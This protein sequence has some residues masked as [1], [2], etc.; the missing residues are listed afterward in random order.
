MV[1]NQDQQQDQAMQISAQ[2][3]GQTNFSNTPTVIISVKDKKAVALLDSGS[4]TSFMDME[5][6]I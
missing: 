5:F 1:D 3:M 2:A 4:N 6:A